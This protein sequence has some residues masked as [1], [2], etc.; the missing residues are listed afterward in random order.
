M[1]LFNFKK[2]NIEKN[3]SNKNRGI[4]IDVNSL[5]LLDQ[6]S[7]QVAMVQKSDGCKELEVF[8][9]QDALIKRY[10]DNPKYSIQILYM[11]LDYAVQNN[12]DIILIGLLPED[13]LIESSDLKP[14]ENDIDSICILTAYLEKKINFNKFI[15]LFSDKEVF[16][17]GE[18]LKGDGEKIISKE[19]LIHTLKHESGKYESIPVFINYEHA[20]KYNKTDCPITKSTLKNILNFWNIY[21]IIIEPQEKYW[22]G[23]SLEDTKKIY[24]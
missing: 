8:I 14:L 5:N 13:I 1:G 10:G 12:K 16:F 18:F 7:R 20:L 17:I 2:N 24:N 15:E 9:T 19:I 22:V 21:G 3:E 6:W 23:I 4:R 11:V